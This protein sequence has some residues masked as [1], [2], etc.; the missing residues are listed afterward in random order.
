MLRKLVADAVN[1]ARAAETVA[2]GATAPLTPK[3]GSGGDGGGRKSAG[4][5]SSSPTARG[6]PKPRRAGGGGGDD[7]DDDD[8]GDGDRRGSGGAGRS[9]GES[10]GGEDDEGGSAYADASERFAALFGGHPLPCPHDAE[11]NPFPRPPSLRARTVHYSPEAVGDFL[12]A[13]FYRRLGEGQKRELCTLIPLCSYLHD[14]CVAFADL[15]DALDIHPR[16]RSRD[17]SRS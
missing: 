8:D 1:A 14:L 7:D 17:Y 12:G 11:G 2:R 9:G 4:G 15:S 13:D 3:S 10:D 5:G 6:T 16:A